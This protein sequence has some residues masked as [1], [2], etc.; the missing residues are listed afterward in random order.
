MTKAKH[1]DPATGTVSEI[2]NAL[3]AAGLMASK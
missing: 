2:V 1:V 3:I